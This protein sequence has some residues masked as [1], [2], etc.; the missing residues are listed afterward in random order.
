MKILIAGFD[1]YATHKT[2]PSKEVL[3]LVKGDNLVKVVLTPSYEKSRKELLAHIEKEKPEAIIIL[4]ID[5]FHKEPTLEQFAYNEMNSIQPDEDGVVMTHTPI[6]EGGPKSYS[7]STDLPRLQHVLFAE[8]VE[9]SCSI[10]GGRFLCN[11]AFYL[12]RHS[13]IPALL[14]HLPEEKHFSL[15]EDAELLKILLEQ[16]NANA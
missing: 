11:E 1:R 8:G 3:P 5:P 14:I 6:V 13:G 12:A 9:P 4:N 15:K 10:D 7:A 2:N 16:I